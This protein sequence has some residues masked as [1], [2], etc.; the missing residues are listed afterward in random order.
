VRIAGILLAA[1]AGARFGGGK[2]L[3]RL[4]DGAT[5][6]ARAAANLRGAVS[7][8]IAVVRPGDDALMREMTEAGAVATVC[9]DADTGMGASLAHGVRIAG[10]VD[11]YLVALADMPWITA[12]SLRRVV[13]GLDAGHPLVVPRYRQQR[14]HPVGFG[15]VHRDALLALSGDTGARALI[16]GATDIHWV[17]VDDPGVVRDVDVPADLGP[18]ERGG[19]VD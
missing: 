11:A 1:G 19:R 17:D 16:A 18:D 14:G 6:G 8:V 3:A 4:P 13:A 12:D 7:D 5:I 10:D 9:A 2:L 15:A